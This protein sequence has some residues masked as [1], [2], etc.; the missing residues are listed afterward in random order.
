MT[1]REEKAREKADPAYGEARSEE[2]TRW[3]KARTKLQAATTAMAA[4]YEKRDGEPMTWLRDELIDAL[5]REGDFSN[6]ALLVLRDVFE[7][8]P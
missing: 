7:E 5:M 3:F 1:G 4:I 2:A 6:A 8:L